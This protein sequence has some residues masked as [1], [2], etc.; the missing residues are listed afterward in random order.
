MILADH[1][2]RKLCEP[3]RT[4]D[5][6]LYDENARGMIE[7]F[8][9]NQ[10]RYVHSVTGKARPSLKDIPEKSRRVISYG[11]TSFGYDMRAG[12]DWKIFTEAG[13]DGVFL[14]DPKAPPD[15]YFRDVTAIAGEQV[16]IPPN[17][18]AL[19]SSL[20]Y[21]RMPE[22]VLGICLGKSTY[23]RVGIE[24]NVTPLEPGWEGEV[25]IEISNATRF[26]VAVYAGEGIMQV[27]FL[28]GSKSETSYAKRNGK[29]QGQRGITLA[30]M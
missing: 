26:P 5:G 2:I 20:E 14:I 17:S 12:Y 10:V 19:T 18:Y 24:L 8:E 27:L 16:I 4:R 15:R 13:T 7:P 9:P 6:R 25:T 30:R 21:V 28:R 11:L 23:A 22:D 1:E 29:Y 3:T